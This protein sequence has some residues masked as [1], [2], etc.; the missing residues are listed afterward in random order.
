[1]GVSLLGINL[2]SV[3][4]EKKDIRLMESLSLHVKTNTNQDVSKW[5]NLSSARDVGPTVP[6][7]HDPFPFNLQV[8]RHPSRPR[9]GAHLDIGRHSAVDAQVYAPH[10]YGSRV[11]LLDF[12]GAGQT[13]GTVKRFR[14]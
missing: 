9:T 14:L 11:G 8:M 1:M 4:S 5:E 6:P 12:T 2:N 3:F 13:L 10:Q 7:I